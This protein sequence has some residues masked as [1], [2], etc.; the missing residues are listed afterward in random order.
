MKKKKT[1]WSKKLLTALFINFFLLEIF[2][3]GVTCYSFKLAFA[4]G[5]TPDYTPLVTL[6]TAVIGETLSYGIYC[7]KA[8]AENVQGGIVYEKARQAQENEEDKDI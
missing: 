5:Q 8:K 3:C 2:I 1:E 4:I 7:A 6:I